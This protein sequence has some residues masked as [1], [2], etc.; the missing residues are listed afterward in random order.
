MQHALLET[1]KRRRKKVVFFRPSHFCAGKLQPHIHFSV[2]FPKPHWR[3][4]AWTNSQLVENQ[5]HEAAHEHTDRSHHSTQ[6]TVTAS[7]DTSHTQWLHHLAQVTP[8][9]HI[10]RHKSQWLH[11]LARV[12]LITHYLT[13][14]TLIICITW[15]KSHWP[16]VTLHKSHWLSLT[17]HK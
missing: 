5:H 9:V 6:V 11:H 1:V 15:H 7:L 2:N 10:T 3:S 8:I 4:H 13:Q 12:T 16:C 17:W 14:V